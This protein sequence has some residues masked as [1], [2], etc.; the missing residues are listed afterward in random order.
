MADLFDAPEMKTTALGPWYGS[1]RMLASEVGRQVGKQ[2]WIG[3]PFCGGMSEVPFLKARAILVNDVHRDIINLA[4]VIQYAD[5]RAWLID[6]AR[7][8]GFHPD[9]LEAAQRYCLAAAAPAGDELF[10]VVRA[11]RY[12]R[13]LWMGRSATAGTKGEFSGNLALR[14]TGSNVRYR[15]A[16][17]SLEAFGE[18]FLNCEFSTLDFREFL[19][20]KISPRVG[21][22]HERDGHAIYSDAPWPEDG[23]QYAHAFTERDQRDLAALLA[24]FTQTRVV[25]RFNDHPLIRELYPLAKWNWHM[26]ES[27][28]QA[29][30]A[31]AEVL[32][33]N[34]A[35]K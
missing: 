26:L 16:I 7:R 27:R 19:E 29:N 31:K 3:V 6:N 24:K 28:T 10:D 14:F 23:D 21:K 9:V 30:K 33:I 22:T 34:G 18:S 17:E 15:S 32:I 12:F 25:I 35:I 11:L 1:N 20:K 5:S 13:T 8:D 2:D 4:R